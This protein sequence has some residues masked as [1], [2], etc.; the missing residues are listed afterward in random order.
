MYPFYL[1]LF[2][3][4]PLDRFQSKRVTNL[5]G[6]SK[7]QANPKDP[8]RPS[9]CLH[10]QSMKANSQAA[11]SGVYRILE[12]RFPGVYLENTLPKL[13]QQNKTVKGKAYVHS[14]RNYAKYF[15]NRHYK[16]ILALLEIQEQKSSTL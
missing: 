14:K 16:K 4:Q 2:A 5:T 7:G 6:L 10:L 11:P 12:Y 1:K 3:E 15:Y 13:R 8:C 9:S